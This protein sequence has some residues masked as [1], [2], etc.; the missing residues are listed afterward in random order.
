VDQLIDVQGL[1]ESVRSDEDVFQISQAEE[2]NRYEHE[3]QATINGDP[4][5]RT[6]EGDFASWSLMPSL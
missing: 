5:T 1:F 6:N 3:Q 4:I 2:Q